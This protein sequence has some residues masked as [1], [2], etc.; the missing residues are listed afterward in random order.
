M[1]VLLAF[2][3]GFFYSAVENWYFVCVHVLSKMLLPRP[4]M[5]NGAAY[6]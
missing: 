4:P 1:H 6:H 5:P 2:K 3:T